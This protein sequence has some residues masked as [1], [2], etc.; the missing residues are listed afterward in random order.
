MVNL[1]SMNTF[2]R[3]ISV[4]VG[5]GSSPFVKSVDGG[6]TLTEQLKNRFKISLSHICGNRRLSR[7]LWI[8]LDFLIR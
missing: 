4:V 8:F 5:I 7:I 6:E 2:S 1:G 3:F